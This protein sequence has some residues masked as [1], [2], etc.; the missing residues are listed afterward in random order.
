MYRGGPSLIHRRHPRD[1]FLRPP[2]MNIASYQTTRSQGSKTGRNYVKTQRGHEAMLPCC[3]VAVALAAPR[4]RGSPVQ[5]SHQEALG[6]RRRDL[7]GGRPS[8]TRPGT[9]CSTTAQLE[10]GGWSTVH[11]PV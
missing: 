8:R 9:G 11:S 5:S 6:R 4:A 10:P 1:V 7:A 3:H 2:L